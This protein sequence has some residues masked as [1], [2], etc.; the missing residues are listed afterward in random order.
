LLIEGK[1][2]DVDGARTLI[3]RRWD[4]KNFTVR[5][6]QDVGFVSNL[7]VSVG[8]VEQNDIGLE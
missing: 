2:C 7:V 4:P 5:I 3:D 8:I 1:V 6:N